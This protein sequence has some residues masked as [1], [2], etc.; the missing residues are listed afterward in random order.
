MKRGI[1]T[2][3]IAFAACLFIN[4][5]V[6]YKA[7]GLSYVANGNYLEALSQFEAAKAVLQ[8]KKVNH[9]APEFIDIE[10][11][12]AY[13]KQC[14][15][16]S[17]QATQALNVLT[18]SD[19]QNAYTQCNTESDADQVQESLLSTLEKAKNAL[20][21]IKSKFS[22]DKVAKANLDKCAEIQSKINGFRGNFSEILA[23]KKALASNTL[24]AFEEFL[25]TYPS[26]N[27]SG[28]AKTKVKE[29]K[30]VV[31]WAEVS[32]SRDFESY[33]Q[34][35]KTYPDGIHAEEA[36]QYLNQ[37]G[38][39]MC[40]SSN[41]EIGTTASYKDYIS[42]YPSG[43]YITYAKQRLAKCQERDYWEAQRAKNTVAA[44]KDY[45]KR[46]PNGSYVAAANNGIDRIAETDVWNKAV[47]T[48]TIEGYQTYLNTSK[49]KAY[50][51]EAEAKIAA[52]KHEKEVNAD[53][54]L[55]AKI[56]NATVSADFEGY[57][58]GKVY[59]G[60]E[61]EARFKYNML[62]AHEYPMNIANANAIVSAINEAARY[63]TL[64]TDGRTL[65]NEAQELSS[66][67][68]FMSVQIA[69]NAKQYLSSFPQ[70][71]HV[72]EV[73]DAY[74]KM[75]ADGMTMTVSERDYQ[76][77]VSYAV[78]RDAK[79]YV[80]RKYR[81]KL[82]A[83]KKYQRSLRVEPCHFLLGVEGALS[84]YPFGTEV[85][86]EDDQAT[87]DMGIVASIGG[88]SNRI[89]LEVG[90]SLLSGYVSARPKINLVK[91]KYFGDPL[92]SRRS[93]SSYT[94]CYLYVAPEFNYFVYSVDPYSISYT[95]TETSVLAEVSD[96][97]S[98]DD[99]DYP[100]KFYPQ[101]DYG[102][103]GGIGIGSDL[104]TFVL[105]GG[106]RFNGRYGY[107]GLSWYFGNK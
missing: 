81:E 2:I 34:Y 93:G 10:K 30:E 41:N 63:G 45:I 57:L 54:V 59:K 24:S 16:F 60:H 61:K 82:S 84:E 77:A 96:Q 21:N 36:R 35:I 38:D 42:R 90:Y 80:D 74:A 15:V 64:D 50:K 26:G 53:E 101:I 102:V 89:N 70:G 47:Q 46:Y 94:D 88:H 98:S 67:G 20:S 6:D 4:G 37:M 1:I 58:N 33:A 69:E 68:K 31:A 29:F 43:K 107:V 3:I 87:V 44:F 18:D 23:W 13:A 75:L 71:A 11:K 76:T 62:R 83:Y 28:A 5:Q 7:K 95:D 73:S 8:S 100:I 25:S 52:I 66:Y 27:Y 72:A 55:W 65:L 99:Y 32:N 22:N 104:G 97:Y 103:R 85:Y 17:D 79:A 105:F 91:K 49:K 14:R 86:S 106:Y 40:W 56:R 92:A 51:Q 78:S 48:N 12:I 19:I 9:N 39:E